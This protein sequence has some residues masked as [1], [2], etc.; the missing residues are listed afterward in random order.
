M[1]TQ[2]YQSVK[3]TFG[4]KSSLW[5]SNVSPQI[6]CMTNQRLP[7]NK[8]FRHSFLPP[9]D[10]HRFLAV[11]FLLFLKPIIGYICQRQKFFQ[12]DFFEN[13][14]TYVFKFEHGRAGV[15]TFFSDI[16]NISDNKY[17]TYISTK[18]LKQSRNRTTYV[19]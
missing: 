13:L 14:D 16:W 17:R 11:D 18:Q 10:G 2:T 5:Q 6:T 8:F 19:C 3:I 7:T 9:T 1:N 15:F 4:Q 12:D